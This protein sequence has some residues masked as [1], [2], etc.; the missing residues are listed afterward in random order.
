M[1]FTNNICVMQDQTTRKLIGVRKC[2]YGLYYFC[3]V[4]EVKAL[5][6]D[7]DCS[8]NL[9]SQNGASIRKGAEISSFCE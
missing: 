4:L 3:G 2:V 5:A 6:V 8:F 1:L 7:R 9:W